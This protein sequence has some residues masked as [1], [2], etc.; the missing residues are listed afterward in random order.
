MKKNVFPLLIPFVVLLFFLQTETILGQETTTYYLIRHAEK[1]LSNK[2][3]N[4][5]H[6]TAVGKQRANAWKTIFQAVAFDKIYSTNYYRTLETA[7]PV[8]E[9]KGLPIVLYDSKDS[10]S[11]EFKRATQ[12]KTVLVV[13]HS[14]T[15]P[16]LANAILGEERYSMIDDEIHGNLYLLQLV[17]NTVSCQL[18]V[19]E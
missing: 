1:D 7:T 15:I 19:L 9:D 14:N 5:P 18:L 11:S 6:L 13:G 8:A 10:F 2:A 16:F 17:E 3:N 12:G 4:N